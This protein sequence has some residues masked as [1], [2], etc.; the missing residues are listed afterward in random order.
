MHTGLVI[1]D[2]FKGQTTQKVLNLLEENHLMYIFV[3]A[4]WTDRLQ[5]LDVSVNRAAKQ[6]MWAKFEGWYADRM[7]AQ[8]YIG[9]DIKPV[10][11]RFSVIKP[12]GAQWVIE[13]YNYLKEHPNIIS[14]GFKHVGITDARV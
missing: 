6:F 14:N 7:I 3:P 2:H 8:K 12:I 11:L 5:P 13:L 9:Q 1:L 4:N 10:D